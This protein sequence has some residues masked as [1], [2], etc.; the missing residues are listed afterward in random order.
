MEKKSNLNQGIII[1]KPDDHVFPK[2]LSTPPPIRNISP[3]LPPRGQDQ[4]SLSYRTRLG[5]VATTTAAVDVALVKRISSPHCNSTV[6]GLF[7][8]FPWAAVNKRGST[9][10]EPHKKYEQLFVLVYTTFCSA[11]TIIM[12]RVEISPSRPYSTKYNSFRTT[13]NYIISV[14]VWEKVYPASV[15]SRWMKY[16]LP[17]SLL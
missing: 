13:V 12:V 14:L 6:D 9:R 1:L 15:L 16:G 5:E 4:P 3:S 11:S 17:H 7:Y 2:I 10:A 8:V